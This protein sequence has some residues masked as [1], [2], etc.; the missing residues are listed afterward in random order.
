MINQESHSLLLKDTSFNYSNNYSKW[1]KYG[2]GFLIFNTTTILLVNSILFYQINMI[3]NEV[4]S[5]NV[6]NTFAQIENIIKL[7]C[8]EFPTICNN[9]SQKLI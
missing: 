3:Y 9:I 2:I 7:A 4:T 1:I 8:I 6:T 5:Q